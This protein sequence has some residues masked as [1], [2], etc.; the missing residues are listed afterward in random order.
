MVTL[1]TISES[2]TDALEND[3]NMDFEENSPYQE[4]VI[5]ETHQ[6]PDKSYFQEL[7]EV[8]GLVITGKLMQK[9]LQKQ[10]DIEQIFKKIQ[11][12]SKGEHIYLY[13]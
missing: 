4:S 12:S 8:Q 2:D 7:P 1:K 3:I 6:R 9:F 10:A 5:S 13:L 11:R